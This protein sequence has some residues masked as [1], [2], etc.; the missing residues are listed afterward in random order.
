MSKR[1]PTLKS[2]ERES[3]KIR[4]FLTRKRGSPGQIGQ[5]F[6]LMEKKTLPPKIRISGAARANVPKFYWREIDP[7]ADA[8]KNRIAVPEERVPSDVIHEVLDIS[9][10]AKNV[11]YYR[12]IL[13]GAPV[14]IA[15]SGETYLAAFERRMDT[16]TPAEQKAAKKRWARKQEED[17]TKAMKRRKEEVITADKKIL[18]KSV[19]QVAQMIKKAAAKGNLKVSVGVINRIQKLAKKAGLK[20]GQEITPGYAQYLKDISSPKAPRK[21]AQR[22]EALAAGKKWYK[23]PVTGKWKKVK[24][25]G[26]VKIVGIANAME[27]AQRSAAT[28]ANKFIKDLQTKKQIAKKVK[29]AKYPTSARGP[30][31][32]RYLQKLRDQRAAAK[33]KR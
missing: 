27:A 22:A 19:G 25:A 33:K 3:R 26:T 29:A 15:F 7:P 13:H 6:P 21:S 8:I 11:E 2:Q 5:K 31:Y 9:G 18:E 20:P 30:S 16:K 28:H 10:D 17:T 1:K 4:S 14:F 12:G 32:Q 23:D 24:P